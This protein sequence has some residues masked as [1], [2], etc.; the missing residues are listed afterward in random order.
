MCFVKVGDL[1]NV[2]PFCEK[3]YCIYPTPNNLDTIFKHC[4]NCEHMHFFSVLQDLKANISNT[5]NLTREDEETLQK[6]INLA[7]LRGEIFLL[8]RNGHDADI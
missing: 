7:V 1:D 6:Q 4:E 8:K 2:T 3:L 5:H